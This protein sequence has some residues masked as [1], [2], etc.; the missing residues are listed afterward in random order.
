MRQ[1]FR[2]TCGLDAVV[3]A[4]SAEDAYAYAAGGAHDVLVEPITEPEILVS[5]DRGEATLTLASLEQI[6]SVDVTGENTTLLEALHQR[7]AQA[8]LMLDEQEQLLAE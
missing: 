3:A 6:L 5:L 2:V 4:V 1:L 8:I 7:L